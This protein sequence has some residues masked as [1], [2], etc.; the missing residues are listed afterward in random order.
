MGFCSERLQQVLEKPSASH[1]SLFKSVICTTHT[2]LH[3]WETSELTV[4]DCHFT[5][6]ETEAQRVGDHPKVTSVSVWYRA[7]L[8]SWLLA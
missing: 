3:L 5:D 6:G 2:D 4:P 8:I 1:H 7:E